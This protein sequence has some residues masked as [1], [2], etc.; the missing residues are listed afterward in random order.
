MQRRRRGKFFWIFM[1]AAVSALLYTEQAAALYV[2][3]TLAICGLM[4]VV[5]FSNLEDRDVE[6]Q[7]AAIKDAAEDMTKSSLD[8]TGAKRRVA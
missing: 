1:A 4:L 8:L 6:M 2:L 7:K 5:A 3:S